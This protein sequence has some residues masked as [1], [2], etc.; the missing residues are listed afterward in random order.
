VGAAAHS[1]GAWGLGSLSDCNGGE[2]ERPVRGKTLLTLE[3]ARF[4]AQEPSK[5]SSGLDPGKEASSGRR[6]TAT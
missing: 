5:Q 4:S 2:I 6:G 1:Q 3:H